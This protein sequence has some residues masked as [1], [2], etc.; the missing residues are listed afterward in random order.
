MLIAQFFATYE[1]SGGAHKK[2]Y[3]IIVVSVWNDIK[4]NGFSL[5]LNV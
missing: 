5:P 4:N 2:A 3:K 1:G